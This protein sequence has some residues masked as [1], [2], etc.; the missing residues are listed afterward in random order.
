MP[1]HYPLTT[2]PYVA[3]RPRTQLAEVHR[4]IGFVPQFDALVVEASASAN[5]ALH[6]R[7]RGVAEAD[8][9]GLTSRLFSQLGLDRFADTKV[10]AAAAP[11]AA[12]CW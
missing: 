1:N 3:R 12:P 11:R 10:G 8:I 4:C 5:L 9:P 7:L 2:T 6:A